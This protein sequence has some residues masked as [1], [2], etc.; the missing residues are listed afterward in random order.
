[1]RLG[2]Q[3]L[4]ALLGRR[5]F[6][7]ELDEEI[8][9]H[10]EMEVEKNLARGMDPA[11]ARLAAVRSFGGVAGVKEDVRAHRGLALVDGLVQDLR[12]ALRARKRTPGF[13]LV[14]ISTLAL[15]V[16]ANTA[17]LS[18]VE[19]VLL[20]P[21]P[22]AD[23]SR[24]VVL[25][26]EVSPAGGEPTP[27]SFSIPE[28]DR[29]R[30]DGR[31][32]ESIVEYHSM[33][34]TLLEEE[35]PERVDTGVVSAGFFDL[36]G[37][38][39]V[40]GR[41]F[42][43]G[44]DAAGAAPVLVL[45]H[46]YWQRRYERDPRVIG[47][48]VEMN[49]RAHRIVGVLPP[50]PRFPQR[51]DV[52]MPVSSCPFRS[53][54][55]TAT[56]LSSR[57]VGAL[58]LLRP[59]ASRESASAELASIA[60]RLRAEEP[61]AYRD[62]EGDR[63]SAVPFTEAVTRSARPALLLLFAAAGFVLLLACANI[64]S[65]H[66]AEVASRRRE[67]ALR[68]ALGADRL[69]IARQLLT[70]SLLVAMGGALLGIVLASFVVAA[71]S[72]LAENLA[73]IDLSGR[74]GPGALYFAFG[75]AVAAGLAPLAIAA[76]ERVHFF[77][78]RSTLIVAQLAISLVL[79]A[80]AGLTL[81]SLYRLETVEAGY[82]TE[83]VLTLHLDLDWQR[84]RNSRS[85]RAFQSTLLA[86]LASI[87]GVAVA[88][89]GRSVPLSGRDGPDPTRIASESGERSFLD[90]HA[91]SPGYFRAIGVPILEGRDFSEADVAGSPRVAILSAAAAAQLGPQREL[92][93]ERE[94]FSI[95]G[96]V[97]DV[98]QY[99]LDRAAE[100]SVYVPLAQFPLRVTNLVV[101]AEGDPRELSKSIEAA[102]HGIDADQ[103]VA[104]VSTLEDARRQSISAPRLLSSLLSAFAVLALAVTAVG[105][106]GTLALGVE[107][108]A[109]EF[110]IRL[111]LGAKPR[112]VS[113]LVLR[114]S[115]A[116]FLAGLAVGL[117][118]AFALAGLLSGLLFEVEPHDPWTFAAVSM[119]LLLV[120]A[121]V[122]L[123]PA[124]K[125]LA[126]DPLNTIRL[127]G[128]T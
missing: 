65:L 111:A 67:L 108:R 103:A 80:G 33:P 110:G 95:V 113:G 28:L 48:L 56:S 71:L 121:A 85:I 122:S 61:E 44:E 99:G 29:F 39:P 9:F 125:A 79:L 53:S 74:L 47:R 124:R 34:F 35:V 51:N 10:L 37:V 50:L 43:P 119:V 90:A 68:S 32:L 93:W 114:Q 45:S 46:E 4:G 91:V 26:R 25:E 115:L 104:F 89:L 82:E 58:A 41:L 11:E 116:L 77:R 100:P 60:A 101:R 1:M 27:L 18:V 38:R 76:F 62:L 97:G 78:A 86:D 30:R 112:D 5:R 21:V 55:G 123:V 75:L 105:L 19:E 83:R 63:I 40:L 128:E 6:E 22:Y 54:P 73:P 12:L 118:A 24:V 117:P 92:L 81:R 127:E 42:L 15:G 17:I 106:G 7:A 64:A 107:R 57:M 87:P 52:F 49:D 16:G 13:T 3:R 70:E 126:I 36:L 59:A 98:R 23:A 8:R 84:Y 72:A 69:R 31:S 88:A 120:A 66:L 102:V 14:A 94:R 2:L 109:R 20:R 96:I